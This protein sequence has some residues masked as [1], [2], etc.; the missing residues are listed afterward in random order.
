MLQGAAN[1]QP[2]QPVQAPNPHAFRDAL[3][4]LGLFEL[5]ANELL[6]NGTTNLNKLR[7][8]T[9]DALDMLIKQIHHDNQGQ[10][11]FI[12]FFSQQYVR[13][14][15]FWTGSM[16]ILGMPYQIDVVTEELAKAWNE[17]IKIK[18]EASKVPSELVK[19]PEAFKKDFMWHTWKESVVTYL[20]SKI[21][22]ASLPPAYLI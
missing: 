1:Q 5:A 11:L 3:M 13:A 10:G 8:L 18:L 15:R 22:Q 9:A 6:D 16:H 2:A 17:K 14:I 7:C 12:P 4:R 21:S 20:H 19:I